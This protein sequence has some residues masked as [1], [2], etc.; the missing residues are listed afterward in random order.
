MDNDLDAKFD[1]K[2]KEL[3]EKLPKMVSGINCAE[4]TL[5]SVLEILGLQ[6]YV[7]NNLIIP[8]AGGFGGYKSKK[9]WMGPCGAVSG[10]CAATG[11]ILAGKER[12]PDELRPMAYFK[13][14]TFARE[15][16][17]EFGSVVC[18]ELCGYDFSDP[19]NFVEY[20]KNNIWAKTCNNFVI[21]AVDAV[22]KI[23]QE[24]LSNWEG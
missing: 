7:Y 14:V 23:M 5:T 12:I 16:E 15:F 3:K 20:Q 18:S 4:L 2:I 24:E 22:R 8:L 1:E 19:N 13:S 6:D 21:W 10:G 9:G 17:K 11:V